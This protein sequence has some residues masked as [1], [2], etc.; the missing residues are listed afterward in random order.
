MM[1]ATEIDK[2]AKKVSKVALI[3]ENAELKVQLANLKKRLR[4]YTLR[5]DLK[6]NL[7]TNAEAVSKRG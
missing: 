2:I 4:K 5:T 6:N 1:D 7:F 3:I